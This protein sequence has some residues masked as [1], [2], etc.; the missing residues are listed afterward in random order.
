MRMWWDLF[1]IIHP[2]ADRSYPPKMRDHH[3]RRCAPS[4]LYSEQRYIPTVIADYLNH[5]DA[6]TE[7]HVALFVHEILSDYIAGMPSTPT[8]EGAQRVPYAQTL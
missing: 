8:T 1:V 5:C 4:S 3:E 7:T 6:P 2:L